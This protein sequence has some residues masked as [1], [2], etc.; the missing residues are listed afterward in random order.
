MLD[1]G[2]QRIGTVGALGGEAGVRM[3]FNLTELLEQQLLIRL[4]E[5]LMYQRAVDEAVA[6][7]LGPLFLC[8]PCVRIERRP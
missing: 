5:V 6:P 7:D 3:L 1:V 4:F 8:K 2:A